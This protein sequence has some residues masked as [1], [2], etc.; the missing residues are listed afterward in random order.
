MPKVSTQHHLQHETGAWDALTSYLTSI[1]AHAASHAAGGSDALAAALA[2]ITHPDYTERLISKHH[3]L[4]NTVGVAGKYFV[5][6]NIADLGGSNS[7]DS[8]VNIM[9]LSACWV[10]R[11]FTPDQLVIKVQAG[12]AADRNVRIGFYGVLATGLPGALIFDGGVVNCATTGIKAV[13][14]TTQLSAGL[15][16]LAHI[17]DSGSL[18]IADFRHA[19]TPLGFDPSSLT[20]TAGIKVNQTYGALPNPAPTTGLSFVNKAFWMGFRIASIP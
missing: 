3:Y 7:D 8:Q 1:T 16:W 10:P 14:Y 13:A 19:L 12:N 4:L 18:Y 6:A 17:K 20:G 15:Y 5:G 11:P 9:C 2:A